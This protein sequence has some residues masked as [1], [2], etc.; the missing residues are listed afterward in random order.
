MIC[1]SFWPNFSEMNSDLGFRVS[2]N[3]GWFLCPTLSNWGLGNRFSMRL[4]ITTPRCGTARYARRDTHGC[5]ELRFASIASAWSRTSRPPN[6]PSAVPG[7]CNCPHVI[8]AGILQ[9]VRWMFKILE[10][11]L[12]FIGQLQWFKIVWIQHF[13][14]WK[15]HR[16]WSL[17]HLTGQKKPKCGDWTSFKKHSGSF[18]LMQAVVPDVALRQVPKELLALVKAATK[19]L[20][21]VSQVEEPGTRIHSNKILPQA[22]PN[23]QTEYLIKQDWALVPA[24]GILEHPLISLYS[25]NSSQNKN[26]PGH[27]APTN[28]SQAPLPSQSW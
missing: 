1:P 17:L 3:A 6:D 5:R 21:N 7:S 12:G 23:P 4:Q 9:R 28:P 11:S 20:G 24:I 22:S 16:N 15:L 19:A 2:L 25:L 18:S 27:H 26:L 14:E 13:Q 8:K 10:H